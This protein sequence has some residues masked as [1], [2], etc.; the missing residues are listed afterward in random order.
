VAS[1]LV[2]EKSTAKE[3]ETPTVASR[4][5]YSLKKEKEKGAGSLNWVSEKNCSS[6]SNI[7]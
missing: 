4:F 3:K 5:R 7:K 2:E 6:S 1:I